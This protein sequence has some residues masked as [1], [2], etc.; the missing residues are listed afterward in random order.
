MVSKH[1]ISFVFFTISSLI[2]V[3]QEYKFYFE[4]SF[5]NK[6]GNGYS[7]TDPSRFL[8]D[9]SI[10]RRNR[11]NISVDETDLPINS[12]YADSVLSIPGVSYVTKSKWFNLMIIGMEDSSTMAKLRIKPFVNEL[13]FISGTSGKTNSKNKFERA[14]TD[15][16]SFPKSDY[17]A[18]LH[19]LEM[20][21]G[22]Y[23]HQLGYKGEGMMI[24]VIDGGFRHVLTAPAFTSMVE[25]GRIVATYDF[26]SNNEYVYHRGEHGT[27]VLST[28]A[29]YDPGVI[30][31]TAPNSEYLLLL[32]ENPA[33][34]HVVE[35]YYWIAAAEFAD[36]AGVDLLNTSLGYTTF[37]DPSENHSYDDMDG[38]TTI[39]TKASDLAAAKG[40]LVVNSVGN[41]GSTDWKYLGA[42][43]DGDSVLAVGAVDSLRQY[44]SFSSKGP[45]AEG[46]IKPN[47]VAMGSGTSFAGLEGGAFKGSGTSFSGPIITGM[48]A[49][50]WQ[51][52]PDRSN[53]EIFNAI[54]KSADRFRFPSDTIGHGIPDFGLAYF[55]LSDDEVSEESRIKVFPNPFADQLYALIEANGQESIEIRIYD[56]LGK[57]V[58]SERRAIRMKDLS[59]I[60]LDVS[61]R[62]S[63]GI[64]NLEFTYG[65]K[66][67]VLKVIKSE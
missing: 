13:R 60:E 20:I 32:S 50:L 42:P 59:L 45:G 28:M 65:D 47:I 6:V 52:F 53:M 24:G 44:A 51:S 27:Y 54:V 8:S 1:Y 35:E 12:D 57:E 5:A 48:A 16:K 43:S 19:Q 21:H 55:L 58:L 4:V 17:G 56:Q 66:Q 14:L 40:I 29:A 25:Q 15:S 10:A 34:E 63:P 61:N 41:S 26:I 64:Y 62:L 67:E 30:I 18:G 23:L 7:V 22:D 3:S 9:R 49:C 31:G 38:N 39:I 46:A 37:D 11:Q 36:S 2:S 33:R